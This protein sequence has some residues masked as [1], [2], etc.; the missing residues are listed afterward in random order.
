MNILQKLSDFFIPYQADSTDAMVSD[1]KESPPP[2][3]KSQIEQ[4]ND[5]LSQLVALGEYERALQLG[6]KYNFFNQHF[7]IAH[8]AVTDNS[9][10]TVEA[11]LLDI[12]LGPLRGMLPQAISQHAKEEFFYLPRS[13]Y[14]VNYIR[15]QLSPDHY[16]QALTEEILNLWQDNETFS[17]FTRRFLAQMNIR[18]SDEQLAYA[19]RLLEQHLMLNYEKLDEIFDLDHHALAVDFKELEDTTMDDY[20]AEQRI[21]L[22][23]HIAEFKRQKDQPQDLKHFQ[24]AQKNIDNFVATGKPVGYILAQ[25]KLDMMTIADHLSLESTMQLARKLNLLD[26]Y[27]LVSYQYYEQGDMVVAYE[28]IREFIHK[29][30]LLAKKSKFEDE[31]FK[32]EVIKYLAHLS[33]CGPSGCKHQVA[34]EAQATWHPQYFESVMGRL[35]SRDPSYSPQNSFTSIV[36]EPLRSTSKLF[37]KI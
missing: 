2:Q 26:Y 35:D 16:H 19:K 24:Q 33:D 13:L 30:Q 11:A 6:R 29:S 37:F 22:Q 31:L 23:N 25:A 14:L 34:Y 27:P 8:Q 21:G 18:D 4:I 20:V 1:E 9:F 10:E 28:I 5:D 12:C 15:K 3:I 36:I 32:S 7:L 17:N